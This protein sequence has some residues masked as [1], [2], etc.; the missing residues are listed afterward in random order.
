VKE[1]TMSETESKPGWPKT[2]IH[3]LHWIIIVNFLVQ[4]CYAAYMVFVVF[5]PE[6]VSGPLYEVARSLPFEE[7]VTRRLYA[8]EFWIATGGLAIYLAITEIA[9]RLRAV[10]D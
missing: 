7:M 1:E 2:L 9:P 6:G 3:L 4:M 5:A 10:N 8:I